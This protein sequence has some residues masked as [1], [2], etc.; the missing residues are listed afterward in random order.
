MIPTEGLLD[1]GIVFECGAHLILGSLEMGGD[2]EGTL[3]PNRPDISLCTMKVV[4]SAG[5][6]SGGGKKSP[7]SHLRQS[8][9][10]Q[11]HVNILRNHSQIAKPTTQSSSVLALGICL[12]NSHQISCSKI[13][14]IISLIGC[15]RISTLH[16]S[17]PTVSY[18]MLV[19]K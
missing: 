14:L 10:H 12:P 16:L 15:V 18:T 4:F 6:S 17:L 2:Q 3:S 13:L 9:K 19:P 7:N 8:Y 11:G 5:G 1:C